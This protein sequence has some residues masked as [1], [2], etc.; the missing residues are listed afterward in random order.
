MARTPKKRALSRAPDALS[1][2][3]RLVGIEDESKEL[4]SLAKNYFVGEESGS[5]SNA[6]AEQ[7]K[8]SVMFTNSGAIQ[9]IYD[10]LIMGLIFENSS[11]LRQNVDAYVTNIDS[12]GHHFVPVLDLNAQDIDEKIRDALRAER[13]YDKKNTTTKAQA[14]ALI[15]AADEP[16][17]A[18]VK[19]RKDQLKIEMR[20][21]LSD[22]EAFFS[23]CTPTMPFAGPE[24]LRGLTRQDLEV[25]GYAYWEVIRNELGDI[26]QFNKLDARS[27]RMMPADKTPTLA[28][29]LR[30]VSSLKTVKVPMNKRFRNYVQRYEGSATFVFYK[31]FGDPRLTSAKTG[32]KYPGPT[33]V[34]D[35]KAD[36][37]EGKEAVAATEIIPFKITSVRSVYGAPRW[38]GAMLAVLGTRQS[39]EVNFLYFENRSI[40]PMVLIVSGGRVVKETV[41]KLEDHIANNVRGKRNF[42]KM[43]II[44]AESAATNDGT[45]ANNGKMK[46]E[47]KPLT[48]AQQQD[49]LFQ[50]YDERNADK[51][52]QTF[53]LPRLLRGDVRDFNR[54]TAEASVDFAEIQVFGPIRQQF[55]WLMNSS[56][57][58][59]LNIQYHAF[60]SNAPTV[61]DPEALANMIA[62]LADKSVITPEEARALARGV[63]NEP[64]PRID[65]EWTKQPIAIT[66]AGRKTGDDG[67]G[68]LLSTGAGSIPG[69]GASGTVQAATGQVDQTKK[70][71]AGTGDLASG[72]ALVPAQGGGKKKPKKLEAMA[73]ALLKIRKAMLDEEREDFQK[74]R[75]EAEKLIIP[76]DLFESCFVPEDK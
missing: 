35:M 64:L 56:I 28:P 17:D 31:E 37:D 69:G 61:R 18:E 9:P 38:I 3:E 2:R 46:I 21:E 34:A 10:P 26:A 52:G 19:T 48:G 11:N 25:F 32:K 14:L 7:D 67:S 75:E 39:E 66:L 5:Q 15:D 23:N 47:L 8:T 65:A 13:R 50:A 59:E 55:D 71:D 24:G 73:S 57:L 72:G 44:E 22:L 58:P 27:I 30:K 54:S 70:D 63:F 60:K 62:L 40:P 68:D 76:K 33:G 53:R 45:G 20:S 16:T 42:H 43:M 6:I 51:V 29:T 41:K 1:L 36:G 49:A 12:F 74:E 4:E